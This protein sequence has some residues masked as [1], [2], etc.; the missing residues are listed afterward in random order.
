MDIEDDNLDRLAK[1]T[2][3]GSINIMLDKM[4]RQQELEYENEARFNH[5]MQ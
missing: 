5:C 4:E 1:L 2:E 3:K